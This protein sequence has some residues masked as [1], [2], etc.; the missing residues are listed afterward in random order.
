MKLKFNSGIILNPVG[1]FGGA[2]RR[3]ANIFLYLC[4]NYPDNIY[5]FVS[6]SL[7][8]QLSEIYLDFPFQNIFT[9]GKE[10]IFTENEK[11]INITEIIT[12]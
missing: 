4:N 5:F 6:H 10:K 7:K 11:G 9:I 8:Q 3:F 1:P 12:E 2:Q